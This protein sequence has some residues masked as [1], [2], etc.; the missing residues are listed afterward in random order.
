[1]TTYVAKSGT[2]KYNRAKYKPHD[3]T[4]VRVV[5]ATHNAAA[6]LVASAS[7][8]NMVTIPANSVILGIWGQS[9][10]DSAAADVE[11]DIGLSNAGG[12]E[13]GAKVETNAAAGTVS[14]GE[15]LDNV[16]FTASATTVGLQPSNSLEWNTGEYA[17]V[18]AYIELDS[19]TSAN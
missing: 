4:L 9:V 11:L 16:V 18:V 19:I 14:A 2:T 6:Q 1:M 13:Y 15:C 7:V 12:E 17:V 8:V 5:K 3:K 10:V